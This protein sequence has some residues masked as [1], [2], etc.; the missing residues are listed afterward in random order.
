MLEVFAGIGILTWGIILV[1]LMIISAG[2]DRERYALST[3]ALVVGGV[4]ILY[5]SGHS[6]TELFHSIIDDPKRAVTVVLAYAV[7][8]VVWGIIKWFFFLLAVRDCLIE[9]RARKGI[10]GSLTGTAANDFFSY[11]KL[12]VYSLP[13]N[14]FK[15]KARIVGWMM[16]WPVSMPWT[17]IN[18]PVKRFFAFIY[19]RIA[20]SLQRLSDRLFDGLV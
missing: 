19:A 9:F 11:N 17:V 6:F 8:G 4:A 16:W 18:E 12:G 10:T 3:I 15:S 5:A 14:A 7:I 20:G 1:T 2:V 13:P